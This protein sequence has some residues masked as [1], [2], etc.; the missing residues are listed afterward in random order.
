MTRLRLPESETEFRNA[1]VDAA[2]LGAKKAL[3]EAGILRPFISE[4]E[5]FRL[6]GEA[7]VRR[8]VEEGLVHPKQDGPNCKKRIDRLE[9]ESVWKVSNRSTYIPTSERIPF[10]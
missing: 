6:Y 3:T 10:K 9:I 4:R 7:V 2:E 5:A 1:L 8:W